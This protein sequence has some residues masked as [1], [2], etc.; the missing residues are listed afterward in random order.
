ML[1]L[2]CWILIL[3]LAHTT[4]CCHCRPQD[5]SKA[6]ETGVQ[7]LFGNFRTFEVR[8]PGTQCP[9]TAQAQT[10]STDCIPYNHAFT[11]LWLT[12]LLLE[13]VSAMS[14]RLLL[15]K[16]LCDC[17]LWCVYRSGVVSHNMDG[18][19]QTCV[20]RYCMSC[21]TSCAALGAPPWLLQTLSIAKLTLDQAGLEAAAA[22]GG[23][24]PTGCCIG[25]SH[26]VRLASAVP[27]ESCSKLAEKSSMH[28]R[29]GQRPVGP[30][31]AQP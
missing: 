5:R 13:H 16:G 6:D 31:S 15:H 29:E 26:S 28:A 24:R 14:M 11:N 4:A 8:P 30:R 25:Q 19:C 9:P 3:F 7:V 27:Y 23:E 20:A 1:S 17:M 22:S 2:C 12:A 21:C 10:G 18:V